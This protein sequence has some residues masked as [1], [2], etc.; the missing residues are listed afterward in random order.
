MVINNNIV[1]NGNNNGVEI[2][3]VVKNDSDD[4]SLAMVKVNRHVHIMYALN[5][6]GF[7]I[8]SFFLPHTYLVDSRPRGFSSNN[9]N[10]A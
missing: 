2:K 5:N 4:S 10:D 3:L 7:R 1:D 6:S 9:A 8:F